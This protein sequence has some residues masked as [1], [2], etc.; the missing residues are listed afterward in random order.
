MPDA[1]RVLQVEAGLDAGQ[2]ARIASVLAVEGEQ[3]D[4]QL[5]CIAAAA[6]EEYVLAVSGTRNPSTIREQRE[7]RLRLLYKHLPAG[8]PT[9]EQVG[10]IFQMTQAQVSTLIAGT[11]ARFEVEVAARLRTAAIRPSLSA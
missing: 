11:R 2:V 3:L 7:L 9:D 1:P 6:L 8:Q 10:L 5:A 4:A